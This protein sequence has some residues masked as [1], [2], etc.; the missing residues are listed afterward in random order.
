MVSNLTEQ[1]LVH[2]RYGYFQYLQS[3]K[4]CNSKSRL[5]E[6]RF[7]CSAHRLMVLCLRF[8]KNISYGLKLQNGYENMV[9]MTA[10]YL[11]GNNSKSRHTRVTVMVHGL[12]KLSQGAIHCV[13][14]RENITKGI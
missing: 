11:I 3:S 14:F 13:N 2:G 12:C 6:L 5:T 4:V 10:H 7:L 1:T 9:E 8:H